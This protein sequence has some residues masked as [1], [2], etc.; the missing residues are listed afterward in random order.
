M[1]FALNL[2]HELQNAMINS[3]YYT[4]VLLVIAGMKMDYQPGQ[5]E[6]NKDKMNQNPYV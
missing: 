2:E 1:T 3:F 6:V 4:F 5:L